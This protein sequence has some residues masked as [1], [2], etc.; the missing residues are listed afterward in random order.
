MKKNILGTLLVL[1]IFLPA[2]AFASMHPPPPPAP[3]SIIPCGLYQDSAKV[4]T[5]PCDFNY[6]VTLAKNV[7][8]FLIFKI[9]APLAALMFAYAGF[10]YITNNGNEGQ[11]KQAHDIFLYVFVGFVVCLAAWLTINMI[12][13]FFVLGSFNFLV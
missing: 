4:T 10:L 5:D 3:S 9:A 11:V 8:E 12:L 13:N 1:A 2:A 6:F 7:I